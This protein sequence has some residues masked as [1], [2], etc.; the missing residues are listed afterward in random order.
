MLG[1]KI[2][3]FWRVCIFLPP[4]PKGLCLKLVMKLYWFI[5]VSF[6]LLYMFESFLYDVV[7]VY[8]VTQFFCK[9]AKDIVQVHFPLGVSVIELS[10]A[11]SAIAPRFLDSRGS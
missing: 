6:L 7:N 1:G 9:C 11:S 5:I 10:E 2:T 8:N 4:L 3:K